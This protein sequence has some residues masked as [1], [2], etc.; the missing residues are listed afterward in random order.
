MLLA[1]LLLLHQY[2]E[3]TVHV[4][5]GLVISGFEVIKHIENLKTDAASRPYADVRVTDCGQLTK[6]A[7]D[8]TE[9]LKAVQDEHRVFL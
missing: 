9:K 5:F 3:N 7:N 2:P 1:D 6:P 4:V 8:D